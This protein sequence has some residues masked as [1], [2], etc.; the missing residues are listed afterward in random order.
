MC[1]QPTVDLFYLQKMEVGQPGLSQE[2][3]ARRCDGETGQEDGSSVEHSGSFVI[4]GGEPDRPLARWR[5][6]WRV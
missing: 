6:V 3:A 1:F 4:D 2:Q 5:L